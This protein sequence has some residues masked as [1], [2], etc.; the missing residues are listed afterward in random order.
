MD[1]GPDTEKGQPGIARAALFGLC[2]QCGARTLFGGVVAF[3]PRCRV[4]GLDLDK[5]NVGDG[6]AGF[7]TLIIGA[8]LVGL[9]LWLDAAVRPPLWVHA[10]I[11]VPV[12]TGAVL[13]GLRYAKGALLAAEYRN[14]AGEGRVREE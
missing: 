7:L 4:C 2:P 6:P 10:L 1:P 14:R 12:T 5:F 8:V 9:A 11:W 13:V 3:A